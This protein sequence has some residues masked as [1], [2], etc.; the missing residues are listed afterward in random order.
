MI[1]PEDP[2]FASLCVAVNVPTAPGANPWI[3]AMSPPENPA[4]GLLKSL[5]MTVGTL[6]PSPEN[7]SSEPPGSM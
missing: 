6:S 5:M 4:V 7:S 3:V 2:S 1:A